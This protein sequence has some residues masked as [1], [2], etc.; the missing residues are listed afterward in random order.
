[1]TNRLIKYDGNFRKS[2]EY[3]LLPGRYKL[4]YTTGYFRFEHDNTPG[5]T[6]LKH[7]TFE[8]QDHF[9]TFVATYVIKEQR[10]FILRNSLYEAIRG[11][12]DSQR[13][14]IRTKYFLRRYPPAIESVFSIGLWDQPPYVDWEMFTRKMEE[15]TPVRI[16]DLYKLRICR[17][18]ALL[19]EV[20][21][22]VLSRVQ[23]TNLHH[24]I[25]H[26]LYLRH[27]VK[28]EYSL[29]SIKHK[30]RQS[31]NFFSLRDLCKAKT[32]IFSLFL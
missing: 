17:M 19:H 27:E 26:K 5:G 11:S 21:R 29:I 12:C 23:T 9:K 24:T 31:V 8:E 32:C 28:S 22:T 30:V 20:E 6:Q 4:N 25:V 14:Q 1:M 13:A 2:K 7:A 3:R 15:Y 16:T 10:L 18:Q